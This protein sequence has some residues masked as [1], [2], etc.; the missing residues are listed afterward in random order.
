M[1]TVNETL[2]A[3]RDYLLKWGR[4][5]EADH[6]LNDTN[7]DLIQALAAAHCGSAYLGAIN[8]HGGLVRYKG[9]PVYTAQYDFCIPAEDTE[10]AKLIRLWRGGVDLDLLDRIHTRIGALGGHLLIWV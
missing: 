9:Q 6:S 8:G 10:L 5:H 3:Q 1:K 7:R 4:P 2:S